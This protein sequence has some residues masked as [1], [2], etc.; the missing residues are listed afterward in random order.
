MGP[1]LFSGAENTLG[2]KMQVQDKP[3]KAAE[4]ALL[5]QI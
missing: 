1:T 3:M 5:L 2:T 4:P